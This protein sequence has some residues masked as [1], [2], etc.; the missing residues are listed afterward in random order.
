MTV[1]FRDAGFESVAQVANTLL[2]GVALSGQGAN[3]TIY[4]LGAN[5]HANTTLK[6]NDNNGA[7]IAYVAAGNNSFP[8]TIAV[9]GNNHIFSSA[10]DA[11]SLFYYVE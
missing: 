7:V 8:C 10:N 5:A 4:L 9:T 11:C 6:Q 2:S 3:T 1:F